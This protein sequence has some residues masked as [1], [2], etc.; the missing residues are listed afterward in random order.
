MAAKRSVRLILHAALAVVL[1]ITF[2]S[3]AFAQ[4]QSPKDFIQSRAN[5]ISAVLAEPDSPKRT[6]RLT[7]AVHRTVDFSE[8][9]SRAL[10]EHWV[11]RTDVERQEF[12]DL[13]QRLLQANYSNQIEGRR[14]GKDYNIDF[15]E[16]RIRD[17]RAVVRTN[18]TY[19]KKKHP[20]VYRL[21]QKKDAWVV[22]DIVIDDVSL[23]E[24]YREGYTPIIEQ[25]GW[26]G[27]I[28]LMKERLVE[29][30]KPAKPT[31]KK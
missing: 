18:V 21:T 12:L 16:E 25:D 26:S 15:G 5:E 11:K 4:V 13:L 24:T 17:G 3:S 31:K 7:G 8:L 23:E 10:G 6:E 2:S 28:D 19:N 30:E 14:L 20:V 27:L 1:L 9:A 29:L 22:Y